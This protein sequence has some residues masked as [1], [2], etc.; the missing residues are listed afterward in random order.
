MSMKLV[1]T[2]TVDDELYHEIEKLRVEQFRG[3]PRSYVFGVILKEG[4]TA[5]RKTGISVEK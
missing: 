2:I 5:I 1:V 4:L 3:A